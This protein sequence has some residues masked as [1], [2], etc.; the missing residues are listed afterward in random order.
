MERTSSIFL[1]KLWLIGG[2]FADKMREVRIVYE[3][4]S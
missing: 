1:E 4:Q 2:Y 3:S